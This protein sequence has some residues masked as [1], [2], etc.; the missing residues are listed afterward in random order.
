[1]TNAIEQV[2]RAKARYLRFA[3]T[4]QWAEFAELFVPNPH[5]RMMSP[6]G[7]V[8][9]SFDSRNAF[10]AAAEA[11]LDGGRSTHM[12]HNDEIDLVSDTEIAATWAMEDIIVFPAPR[13]DQPARHHGYGRYHETWTL[14]PDGWRIARLELHRSVLDI[15]KD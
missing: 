10:V 11:Y 6:D 3:D 13:P 12:V 8:L 7:A 15:T 14:T 4:K 2:R 5:I 1:M 9:A